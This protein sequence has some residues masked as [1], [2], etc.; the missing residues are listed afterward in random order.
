MAV[1][2]NLDGYKILSVSMSYNGSNY[3]SALPPPD[4]GGVKGWV[5]A[6]AVVG[7]II[8]LIVLLIIIGVLYKKI[9]KSSD[10]SDDDENALSA[11]G[12]NT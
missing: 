3:N 5:I 1:G 7:G 11:S 10:K 8:G 6:V 12:K 2:S 4:N 9:K